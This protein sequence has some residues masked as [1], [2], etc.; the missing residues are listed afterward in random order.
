MKAMQA[1]ATEQG[2]ALVI[3]LWV[4]A[5]LSS[6]A[7]SLAFSMRTETTLAYDLAA[8]AQARALAEA[9]VYRGILELINPDRLRRW[10]GDG[11]RHRIRFGGAPITVSVQD[12]AGKIDLNS[13]QRELLDTLLR[14]SGVE[15]ERRDALLDAIE[16]W[17]DADNLRRLN[18]AEDQEYEA[19]GR[20]YGAKDATFNTVEELQQVLGVTP[21]LFR[22][23]RPALTVHSHSAGIDDRLAPPAVLRALLLSNQDP[24]GDLEEV[25][26]RRRD[27]AA[28]SGKNQR[29]APTPIIDARFV[30]P[31]NGVIYTVRAEAR[32]PP[33][34]RASIAATIKLVHRSGKPYT[35]L[36]WQESD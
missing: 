9:G 5:L 26:A 22:R 11:S 4:L 34:T 3:V 20:T 35:V 30:V 17:R 19:A 2:F 21:R 7:A 28:E 8:Q 6:L 24:D 29:D 27:D 33:Q 32:L 13:A 14:A 18:G 15:D 31:S 10:R 23:L 16:D 12:E 1:A 36:T 25:L